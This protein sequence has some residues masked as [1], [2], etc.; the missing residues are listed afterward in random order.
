MG[1]LQEEGRQIATLSDGGRSLFRL[2]NH[3]VTTD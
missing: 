1:G 3:T 2:Q